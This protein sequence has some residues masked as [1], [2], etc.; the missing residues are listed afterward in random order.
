MKL[1]DELD[2]RLRKEAERRDVTV[3]A[4]VREAIGQYLDVEGGRRRLSFTAMGHGGGDVA[5]RIDEILRKRAREAD[6]RE[7]L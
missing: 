4:L 3:S 2:A 6:P 1:P 5:E 7:G